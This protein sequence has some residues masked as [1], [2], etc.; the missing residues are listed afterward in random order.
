MKNTLKG[1]NI[2]ILFS[3]GKWINGKYI[4]AI[5][6]K[7]DSQKFLVS[8]PIKKFKKATDRNKIKRYLRKGLNEIGFNSINIALIYSNEKIIDYKLIKEDISLILK[9][10]NI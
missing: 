4:K 10:I 2:E 9:N 3:K 6:Q 8:A 5:W 1:K 7:S